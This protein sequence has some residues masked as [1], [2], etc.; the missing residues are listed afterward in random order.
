[1]DPAE[2]QYLQTAQRFAVVGMQAAQAYQ[3]EQHKLQLEDVLTRERLCTPEGTLA[4][5]A[6]LQRLHELTQAH[7]EAF[8]SLMLAF[9]AELTRVMAD[10]PAGLREACRTRHAA[11][12]N[13]TLQV[14]GDFYA[15]RERWIE[16]ATGVCRLI[17]LRR[18]TA[19]FGAEGVVF[20][21]EMD[22]GRLQ[23]LMDVIDETHHFEVAQLRLRLDRIAHAAASMGLRPAG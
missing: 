20:A 19:T 11:T 16:A 13:W 7:K 23:A 18:P 6:A 5:L 4:S 17:E 15:N 1:M 10:M 3:Q 12:V 22:Y 14:Q 21:D 2:L 9:T 8:R